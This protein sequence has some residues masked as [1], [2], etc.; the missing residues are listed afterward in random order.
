MQAIYLMALEP[1]AE[2][3][4]D[5]H[6]YGFRKKRKTM[7]A[8]RQIHTVLNRQHS[9][10]WILEGDIKGC[11]DHISHEWLRNNIP[12][13]KVMSNKWLKSGF[14]F[15]GE[16]FPTEEGTP[17]GGII[18]PTL[19][20]MTLD[21]LQKLLAEKYKRRFI[22]YK[23]FHYKVIWHVMPMTSLL[24]L[25]VRSFWRKLNHWLPVPTHQNHLSN[26]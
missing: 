1:V 26:K 8:I 21:G 17:Q 9:P 10:E 22:N 20:N 2:T 19:T 7:D 24:L 18:S 16:L 15:N 13:D 14:I 23:T 12:M 6:S 5:P 3:T 25:E 4:A 11:F